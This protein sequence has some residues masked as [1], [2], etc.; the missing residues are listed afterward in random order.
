MADIMLTQAEAEWLIALDKFA[1][2]SKSIAIPASG[3][4]TVPLASSDSR[5]DF[6]LDIEHGRRINL[7]RR[8]LQNRAREIVPLVRLDFGDAAPHRNP[9][10]E[11]IPAP[12]LHLYREGYEDKWAYPATDVFTATGDFWLTLDEFMRYCHIVTPPRIERGLLP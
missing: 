11:D 12:H 3:K 4:L 2:G 8:K 5:E 9:D 10:D 7:T 6:L 1:D